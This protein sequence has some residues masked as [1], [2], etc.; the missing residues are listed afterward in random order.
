[1]VRHEFIFTELDK[2]S[3]N[4]LYFLAQSVSGST[5]IFFDLYV[6]FNFLT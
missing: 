4:T 6:F 2:C 1:M 5:A 3:G